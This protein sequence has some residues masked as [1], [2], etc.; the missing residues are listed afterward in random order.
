MVGIELLQVL[1]KLGQARARVIDK[2]LIVDCGSQECGHDGKGQ[3]RWA[4][5]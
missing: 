3:P 1:R 5:Y 2:V 4:Q